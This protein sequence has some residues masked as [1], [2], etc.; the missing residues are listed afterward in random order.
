MIKAIHVGLDD[1]DSLKGGCTTYLAA[2]I[3]DLL[4]SIDVKFVDYPSLV[5][6]N[7]NIPWKTRGNGA[8]SL[9][10]DVSEDYDLI[11]ELI[12]QCVEDYSD[13]NVEGT[14]P[15]VALLRGEVPESLKL[16]SQKALHEVLSLD[17]AIKL[18]RELEGEALGLNTGRGIIGALAAIGQM[19]DGDHTYE[20][21]TYRFPE[22]RGK[23]RKINL[24]SVEEMSRKTK[25]LTFS[26]LDEEIGRVLITPRGSD[27]VLFGVRGES[28][29][30]VKTAME[31]ISVE[32][33]IERWVIFQTNQG[34]D[35]HLTRKYKINEVKSHMPLIVEGKIAS[36]PWTIVGGHVFFKLE[37]ETGEI[38][39]AAYEPTGSFRNIIKKLTV[40][41]KVKVYGGTRKAYPPHSNTVNIEKIEI[42]ELT[43]KFKFQ[44]PKC[45]NC[46]RTMKSMGS[47]KGFR[48]EYC[49]Y[50][51]SKMNKLRVEISRDVIPSLHVPPPRAHRHLT[52][53][54]ERYGLEKK[55][56]TNQTKTIENFWG[57]SKI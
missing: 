52:K 13:L 3:I 14:N 5:R 34:T 33:P 56:V 9:K 10:I 38:E 22:Y 8:V 39:C 20:A 6:L 31:M 37:D 23:L 11:K 1:T 48:C 28:P 7:P 30:I 18:L 21:I 53:P 54:L 49:K 47:N 51:N 24:K 27:P 29:D 26:N 32:E 42:L 50:R 19:F 17:E 43:T 55:G 35:A 15:G 16:F 40:N 45:P 36:N 57:K 44:N 12:F 46:N 25:P 4:N 2:L 41:D